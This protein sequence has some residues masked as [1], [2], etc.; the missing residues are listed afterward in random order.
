MIKIKKR[1]SRKR[2]KNLQVEFPLEMSRVI[3]KNV[4]MLPIAWSPDPAYSYTVN[5]TRILLFTLL[6]PC[7]P[8]AM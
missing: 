3:F 5:N 1:V 2:T 4:P 7:Y 6:L 8:Y